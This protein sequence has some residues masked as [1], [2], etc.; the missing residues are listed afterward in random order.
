MQSAALGTAPRQPTHPPVAG[1]ATVTPA[2][3]K[4]AVPCPEQAW[5]RSCA[6]FTALHGV[7]LL[8]V[9]CCWPGSPVPEAQGELKGAGGGRRA[10]L[11]YFMH[12]FPIEFLHQKEERVELRERRREAVG[13]ADSCPSHVSSWLGHGFG[14]W[15]MGWK[16]RGCDMGHPLK[17][18]VCV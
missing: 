6:W 9:M 13:N 8:G 16:L 11:F 17:G 10:Y 5:A 7:V 18:G 1:G 14:C 12:S 2:H 4:A 3:R 15:M